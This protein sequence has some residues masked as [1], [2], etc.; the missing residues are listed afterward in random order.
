MTAPT[1][2]PWRPVFWE[3]VAGTTERLMVGVLYEFAGRIDAK[4]IMRD[5]VL[6]CLYG[7]KQGAATRALIDTA[8]QVLSAVA[9]AGG[10]ENAEFA[11]GLA[12]G[13]LRAT[14]AESVSDLLRTAALLYSSLANIDPVE[15]DEPADPSKSD[16]ANRR[17]S[18][19]VRDVIAQQHP[20][21]IGGFGQGGQL[22]PGG[23]NVRFGYFSPAFIA[24]FSILHPVHQAA[25]VSSARARLWELGRAMSLSGITRGA[26]VTAVPRA[27]DATLGNRQRK[28][29]GENI[30]EIEREAAAEH[31]LLRPVHDAQAGAACIIEMA[32][33]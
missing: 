16:Q 5:D 12:P 19:E 9:S 7:A 22:T 14:Q 18:T 1:L 31:I 28:T 3:P 15:A 20:E 8:L 26:L 17:F 29:L 2:H 23:R 24:H 30:A 13:D 6:D 32:G 10:I 33:A 21:L 4:R 11:L 25:S 27:D